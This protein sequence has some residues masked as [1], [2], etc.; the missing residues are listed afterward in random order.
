MVSENRRVLAL[1][2]IVVGVASAQA[3]PRRRHAA[4]RSRPLIAAVD[5]AVTELPPAPEPALIAPPP[6]LEPQKI[7]TLRER[8]WGLFGGGLALFAAGWAIDIGTS[9]GVGHLSARG[10]FMESRPN[11]RMLF[12]DRTSGARVVG[13]PDGTLTQIPGV[14]ASAGGARFADDDHV[15]YTFGEQLSIFDLTAKSSTPVAS[16][17]DGFGYSASTRRLAYVS[18]T[19][20]LLTIHVLP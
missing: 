16:P 17:V 13:D 1:L 4:A 9:Y 6:K 19:S 11:G 10:Q 2:A 15:I 8:R 12:W 7:E 14:S 5:P 18:H 3:S 20:G